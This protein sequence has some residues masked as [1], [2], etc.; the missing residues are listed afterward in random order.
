MCA[1]W[2]PGGAPDR[3]GYRD[4][5]GRHC[6]HGHPGLGLGRPFHRRVR[7]GPG[8]DRRARRTWS[9]RSAPMAWTGIGPGS[10]LGWRPWFRGPQ[11]RS[12]A[13]TTITRT[14]RGRASTSRF[15]ARPVV[16]VY[17]LCDGRRSAPPGGRARSGTCSTWSSRAAPWWTGPEVRRSPPMWGSGTG[18][19]SS[20]AMS[21]VRPGRSSTPTE[22]W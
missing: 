10:P 9:I 2:G 12:T 17:R 21:P 14:D 22:R 16:A 3:G 7:S 19:S 4:P 6:R 15:S 5:D 13:R 8:S 20:W 11:S 18:G 1:A